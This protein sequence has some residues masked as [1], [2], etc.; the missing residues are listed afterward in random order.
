MS[1][2]NTPDKNKKDQYITT[3][4]SLLTSTNN[5]NQYLDNLDKIFKGKKGFKGLRRTK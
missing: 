3:Q 5:P 2:K 4:L 1:N